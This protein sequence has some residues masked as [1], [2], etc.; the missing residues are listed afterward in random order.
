MIAAEPQRQLTLGRQG[1]G[2]EEPRCQ[3][4]VVPRSDAGDHTFLR[5]IELALEAREGQESASRMTSMIACYYC[6]S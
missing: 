1:R 4:V 2:T 5:D 6:T 3:A